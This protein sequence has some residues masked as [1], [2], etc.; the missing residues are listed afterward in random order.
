M[1]DVIIVNIEEPARIN[2][3]ELDTPHNEKEIVDIT[4]SIVEVI[5]SVSSEMSEVQTNNQQ[6]ENL[7]KLLNIFFEY[8]INAT[9]YYN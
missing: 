7:E 9:Q 4:E 5:P 6:S 8:Y 1:T 2:E 3:I